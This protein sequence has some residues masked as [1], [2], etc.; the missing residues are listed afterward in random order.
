MHAY[1][2]VWEDEANAR[3]V[4]LFVHYTLD[5]GVVQIEA[6]EPTKVTLYDR[7][8][9]T[10]ARE[11]K[12]WTDTGRRVLARAYQASRDGLIALEDE[13]LAQHQLRDEEFAAEA[14][15]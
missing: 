11:L 10:V 1:R 12:V 3:E 4:E 7:V 15:S 13:I 8:A 2:I 9:K 5:N 6:V 14:A